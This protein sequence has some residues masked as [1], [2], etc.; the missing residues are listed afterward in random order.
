MKRE[1]TIMIFF[2]ALLALECISCN[3]TEKRFT[4]IAFDETIFNYGG[5]KQHT[6]ISHDFY[7]TNTGEFPL[8]FYTN[9]CSCICDDCEKGQNSITITHDDCPSKFIRPG[10]RGKITLTLNTEDEQGGMTQGF[11]VQ[12][13]TIPGDTR[14]LFA[15]EIGAITKDELMQMP[16]TTIELSD[17]MIFG[18]LITKYNGITKEIIVKNTGNIPLQL[19]STE[20]KNKAINLNY[21]K[22][23]IMPNKSTKIGINVYEQNIQDL[24]DYYIENIIIPSNASHPLQI[25]LSFLI[26]TPDQHCEK[27]PQ[28]SIKIKNHK[29]TTY[30]EDDGS[31]HQIDTLVIKNTGEYPL[32]ILDE[33]YSKLYISQDFNNDHVYHPTIID[34]N[35]EDIIVIMSNH[36]NEDTSEI[37][38][39]F[40]SNANKPISVKIRK[41]KMR[42]IFQQ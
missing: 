13:N 30:M 19:L 38:V 16:K 12:T 37:I 31:V 35:T 11:H 28:T 34:K 24:A 41:K 10:K 2:V 29:V 40:E 6:T 18:G 22:T 32:Y 4:S 20:T 3:D 21:D 14:L 5:V 25:Y 1:T 8:W 27:L 9:G 7:F 17:T 23:P 42:D 36:S 15:Y 26:G 33:D 39:N